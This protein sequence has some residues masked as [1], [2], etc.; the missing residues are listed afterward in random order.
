MFLRC[1][2]SMIHPTRPAFFWLSIC[3]FLPLS[4]CLPSYL[5]PLSLSLLVFL[6]LPY[7]NFCETYSSISFSESI[8]MCLSQS[9]L[10]SISITS[11]SASLTFCR[12]LW[13][14][15][16]ELCLGVSTSGSVRMPLVSCGLSYLCV[17]LR[18]LLSVVHVFV[19]LSLPRTFLSLCL[20]PCL[21]PSSPSLR[22]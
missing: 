8:S 12:P 6:S 7:F 1:F 20:H 9:Q 16:S 10:I 13:L 19:S 11:F 2:S 14:H 3:L 18:L 22:Y 15:I 21:Y 4:S 17:F 5:L